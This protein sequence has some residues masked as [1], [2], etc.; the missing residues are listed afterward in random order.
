MTFHPLT[1]WIL[2]YL[3]HSTLLVGVAW[4]LLKAV[5]GPAAR[6]WLLRGALLAPL[7]TTPMV[8]LLGT[9]QSL[10]WPIVPSE[11]NSVG[12][13]VGSV[14]SLQ[15]DPAETNLVKTSPAGA[16]LATQTTGATTGVATPAS[17]TD[18]NLLGQVPWLAALLG[19]GLL[20]GA[21]RFATREWRAQR[22]LRGRTPLRDASIVECAKDIAGN[23]GLADQLRLSVLSRASMPFAL[24][25]QEIVC[26]SNLK[27]RLDHPS[28]RALFAHEVAHL[29]RRDPLWLGVC[30]AVRS[31]LWMQPLNLWVLSQLETQTELAADD[32]A[33]DRLV[34][35][36]PMARLLGEMGHWLVQGTEPAGSAAISSKPSQLVQRIERLL[37]ARPV[38]RRAG[39]AVGL[40][41]G[42]VLVGLLACAGPNVSEPQEEIQDGPPPEIADAA[43]EPSEPT[44]FAESPLVNDRST[45]LIGKPEPRSSNIGAIA[46]WSQMIET[47][48]SSY[49]PGTFVLPTEK[50]GMIHILPSGDWVGKRSA[51]MQTFES[52]KTHLA[53][54]ANSMNRAPLPGQANGS[55]FPTGT[56]QI[57]IADKTPYRYLARALQ[58]CSTKDVSIYKI[59]LALMSAPDD[60]VDIS[61]PVDGGLYEPKE[62]LEEEVEN[63]LEIAEDEAGSKPALKGEIKL[64]FRDDDSQGALISF[65]SHSAD[66]TTLPDGQVNYTN[67]THVQVDCG[68]NI[69]ASLLFQELHKAYKM[70]GTF[71]FLALWDLE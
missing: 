12:T 23:T 41:T 62:E 47:F 25:S 63:G 65:T 33:A 45:V 52:A 22:S 49:A 57:R 13:N 28:M 58:A 34:D 38:E 26:P 21:L 10:A 3:L 43:E 61:L 6:V 56:L 19:M 40:A 11:A 14:I 32:W 71:S 51:G 7:V 35:P 60:F 20:L 44:T 64:K 9:N 66:T 36:L 4:I 1:A 39:Q 24:G 70:G 54:L 46:E 37:A 2:T 48:G 55:A 42:L 30:R 68:A 69:P 15:G 5:Q 18:S 8:G 29:V 16:P 27:Q 53:K 31:V 59:E 50:G 17:P 67:T